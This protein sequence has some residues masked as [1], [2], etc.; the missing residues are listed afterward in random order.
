M[1]KI[2]RKIV[3]CGAVVGIMIGAYFG[4]FVGMMGGV[5]AAENSSV[6]EGG[7]DELGGDERWPE[8]FIRAVNPGYTIDGLKNVGEMIEIG[9]RDGG[10]AMEGGGEDAG[11]DDPGKLTLLAGVT[12]RY[13]TSGGSR[14]DLV[15][16]PENSYM[17]GESIIL[18]L[19]SSPDHELANLNYTKTLAS[20]GTV[21]IVRDG[22]VLDVVCWSGADG[23]YKPLKTGGKSLVRVSANEF[24]IREDYEPE[25]RADNYRVLE[26]GAGGGNDV[27]V[28]M[29]QCK[30]V[31][32]SEILSYYAETQAE[33][34]VELYNTDSEQVLLD[35]CM[36][37]YKGKVYPLAGI[38]AAEGY[39][40]RYLT[41]FSVTK[42][43][44]NSG[45]VE[46]VD[47]TGEVVSRLEYPNGQRKGTSWAFVGYDAVGE[48]LWRTTYKVT[49][50]EPN[51]YQEYKSCEE[52]KVINEAT[53]NCVKVTEVAEKVC[54]EGQ[55][56][57]PLTGR[58]KKNEEEALAAECK[59]GYERN[60]ETGRCRKIKENN[61]AEYALDEVEFEK[62]SSFVA[63]YIIVG[64][65]GAGIVYIIYEFRAEIRRLCGRVWRRFH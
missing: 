28:M 42:N 49:P 34:F 65:V 14:T 53:G 54:A 64:V 52:G 40:V 59:E 57:N 4:G 48:E 62:D 6:A 51:V 21:E 18:R 37:R 44:T 9:R 20:D 60:P 16:F 13:T 25:Y 30:G 63:V 61:G 15:K 3:I 29:P 50:G 2:L 36:L 55:Y 58:C 22:E 39:A 47:V 10:G 12:V 43:P 35:G 5:M 8:F 31:I 24:E 26:S 27:A 23:C 7:E 46:L 11:V 56:L 1:K 19:A 38:V 45:V 32:F 17:S 41:D 33:Q